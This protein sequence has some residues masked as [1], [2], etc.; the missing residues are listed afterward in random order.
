MSENLKIALYCRVSKKIGQTVE[1]QVPILENWAKARGFSYMIFLEE[2]STRKFRPVRAEIIAQ[3]RNKQIDGVACVRLDRFLRSLSEILLIKELIEKGSNFYFVNQ[4]LEL[5]TKTNNAMSQ[6]QLGILTVFAEFERELIRER[7]MEGL[8]RAKTQ[9]KF[10]GRPKGSKDT[11]VRKKS[12]YWLRWANK[13]PPLVNLPLPLQEKI[14]NKQ[15]H[16]Y[17]VKENTDKSK[18]G[19]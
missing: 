10:G 3:L 17:L 1:N 12:G 11:K 6:M 7:V 4:G 14:E 2:E 13:K 18:I 16:D 15:S 8:E 19:G 9:N 5:N